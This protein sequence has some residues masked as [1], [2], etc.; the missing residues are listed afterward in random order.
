MNFFFLMNTFDV[1]FEIF[2]TIE[3]FIA[4]STFVT[5]FAFMNIFDVLGMRQNV[6]LEVC[7]LCK[8]FVASIEWTNIR[9]ITRMDS[10]VGAKV[11]V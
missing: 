6:R 9:P 10:D 1:P 4:L 11:E 8:F 5:S 7:G 2:L 3:G